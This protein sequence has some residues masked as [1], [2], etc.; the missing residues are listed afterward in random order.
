MFSIR[1]VVFL[2]NTKSIFIIHNYIYLLY[3]LY[4]IKKMF[5]T[6]VNIYKHL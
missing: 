2:F 1:I 4:A 6:K 3:E 5:F